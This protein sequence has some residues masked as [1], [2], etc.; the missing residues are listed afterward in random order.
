MKWTEYE[1]RFWR[2]PQLNVIEDGDLVAG[3]DELG[4]E[5]GTD[6]TRPNHQPVR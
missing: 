4:G 1:S 3:P 2:Q 5:S 6:K